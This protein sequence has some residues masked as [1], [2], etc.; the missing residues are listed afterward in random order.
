MKRLII[1]SFSIVIILLLPFILWFLDDKKELQVA[2]IDKTVPD[3][4]FREHLGITWVLNHYGYVKKDGAPYNASVDYM[5]FVPN[6]SKKDYHIKPLSNSYNDKDVIYVADTY[7]VYNEDLPWIKKKREGSRSSL[8]YG[9]LQSNEWEAILNR[10]QQEKRSTFIAEFNTLASP[11]EEN[12]R[13]SMSDY[14]HFNWSGWTGR[15]F[16]ELNSEKNNEIPQWIID[17]YGDNWKYKG[18]GFILINDK[19]NDVVVLEKNKEFTGDGINLKFTKTGQKKFGLKKS[20]N[21]YYWFDIV[22][23]KVGGNVLAY[24]NWNLTKAGKKALESKGIPLEFAGILESQYNN[25]KSYYFAGD[26]ND[27]STTPV[28]YK[29]KGLSVLHKIINSFSNDSFYWSTYVPVMKQILSESKENLIAK[30]KSKETVKTSYT[31]RVVDD[32]FE[33]LVNNNWKKI[34]IKGV[35][36]GMG[37]PGVFPGEAAITEEEY[38]RWLT[39]IGEMGAN[40][41]R[42]YTLHPPGFYKALKRYN[43]SHKNPIYLFHGVWINEESLRDTLDSFDKKN[44]AEFQKEMKKTVD[45]I[46]GN[47]I[48][49]HRAGHASGIYDA[50][51]SP[52]V[53]GWIIGIEWYPQMVKNTNDTHK[54]IGEYEGKYFRTVNGSAFEHWLASQLDTIV[55]YE[56]GKYNWIR[57]V[58][59]T[60]W[61]TTDILE[62][63]SEPNEDE[64]L[65]SVNPNVI[66]TKGEM[67]KTKQFASYHVYPYYP[68]FFNYEEKYLKYVDHRGKFNS[69]AAYLKDLHKAHH[70]PILIAEFGVPASRGLTH[71]NPMGRTQGF[72][73][74]KEQGETVVDMYEDILHE[75]LLGGL[76]F[77]WQD[78]WFKRTW[79]TMDYDNPDRRPFWSNAQTN[80]QQFGLMSFDRDKIKVDGDRSDWKG[81][82]PVYT[83]QKGN[84]QQL[85]IDHDERYLY[86]RLEM[87]D[88]KNGYPAI[89]LDT[90]KGQGN[91]RTNQLKNVT[92]KNGVDF[93]INLNKGEKS[94]ILVDSYYDFYRFQYGYQF[95]MIDPISAVPPKDSGSF[96][97]VEYALNKE[98]YIPSKDRVIPFSAYETGKLR[99][100][101]SNPDSKDYDS[102]AD[103]FVNEKERVIEVRIPWLL[104]NFKDPSQ[105]EVMGDFYKNGSE[106]SEKIDGVNVGVVFAKNDGTV[107]DSLPALDNNKLS[108]METYTWKTWNV[109]KYKE[110]LKESYYIVKKAFHEK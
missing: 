21:Y 43:E 31:S 9:G 13:K 101:N 32:S 96:K 77:T 85:Y 108:N 99:K 84:L 106:A 23:P 110:R 19:N 30:D 41:I 25:S 59:F 24:Y 42:I 75:N 88:L 40:T 58:S 57:P 29:M 48:I 107:T 83:K 8:V 15:Y 33:V 35:N 71:D 39:E 102:L 27:I 64:D 37:K 38:Y 28:F 17:E 6:E 70:I 65:V 54:G 47:S 89:L 51:I 1:I 86:F 12:V 60:N 62:H 90:I 18:P 53:I 4:S 93:I 109:P 50:D 14:L 20:P 34:K 52:Y 68:D 63:P 7:G 69:Y 61:V 79:N 94:K 56:K 46:H 49:K 87:N 80:E 82:S 66:Q 81:V 97:K 26:F 45:V 55:S 16:D 92:F 98:L 76:I 10:L 72:L 44:T 36:M 11:T 105:R 104:L 67:N 100:G 95:K 91:H 22:T 3:E 5:G 78:E 74:E 73:S 2:I 103:Y